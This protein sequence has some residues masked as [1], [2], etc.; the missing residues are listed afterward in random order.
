MN[1]R[2]MEAAMLDMAERGAVRDE[3]GRFVPGMSGNPAGKLLGTRN[4]ATV[5]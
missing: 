1:N 3:R 2:T 4:R 5:L